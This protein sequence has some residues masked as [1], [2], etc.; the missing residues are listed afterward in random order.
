ME[1]LLHSSY[2][3]LMVCL[4]ILAI[5]FSITSPKKNIFSFLIGCGLCSIAFGV[6]LAI[7]NDY[8][9]I[10]TNSQFLLS[11]GYTLLLASAWR[12]LV[13]PRIV[14]FFYILFVCLCISFFLWCYSCP[15]IFLFGINLLL[16]LFFF[17]LMYMCS[18]SHKKLW[19]S[20]TL[21]VLIWESFYIICNTYLSEWILPSLLVS[22]EGFFRYISI[23][24]IICLIYYYWE[25]FL[26]A[27][28]LNRD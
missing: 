7:L 21:S 14:S 24:C 10:N 27:R 1:I 8:E 20:I 22:F 16:K 18:F 19:A 5:T 4:F 25:Q 17:A 6:H 11:L 3:L 28:F 23:F 13:L 12:L 26:I 9:I 2:E 15:P